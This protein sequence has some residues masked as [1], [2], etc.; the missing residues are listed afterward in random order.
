MST[1]LIFS[2]T[3][4]LE[5]SWCKQFT[6]FYCPKNKPIQCI[7]CNTNRFCCHQKT[8]HLY[9]YSFNVY[10]I[11]DSGHWGHGGLFSSISARSLQPENY[12]TKAGQM[13]GMS[14]CDNHVIIM[15][16]SSNIDGCVIIM[17]L[18]CDDHVTVMYM[19]YQ[20]MMYCVGMKE[21]IWSVDYNKWS[22]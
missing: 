10:F 3:C 13:K 21:K 12:Y 17:W 6:K 16:Q 15:W 7:T 5:Y 20:L 18:S 9:M 11:D 4:K 22:H 14:S 19:W 2:G 1:F 8:H